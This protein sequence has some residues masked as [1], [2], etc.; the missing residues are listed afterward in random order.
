MASVEQSKGTSLQHNLVSC[1]SSNS[2]KRHSCIERNINNSRL[3]K[4]YLELRSQILK[5]L[6][7][8]DDTN[9]KIYLPKIESLDDSSTEIFLNQASYD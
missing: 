1:M 4:N 8:P 3:N 6:S 7:L 9:S 2:K 5:K